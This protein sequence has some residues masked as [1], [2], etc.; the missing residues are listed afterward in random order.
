[1]P[2]A[3]ATET[4]LEAHWVPLLWQNLL[5]IPRP[6]EYW[7]CLCISQNID[8]SER[9]SQRFFFALILKWSTKNTYDWVSILN[10]NLTPSQWTHWLISGSDAHKPSLSILFSLFFDFY[11]T[12]ISLLSFYLWDSS[13]SSGFF[14]FFLGTSFDF[15]FLCV[16]L[17]R[18]PWVFFFKKKTY[19]SM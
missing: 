7:P 12:I 11:F 19:I 17:E 4:V 3:L 9:G 15:R 8:Y 5:I 2:G 1:M 16:D 13:P 18:K 10:L 6:K 14:F